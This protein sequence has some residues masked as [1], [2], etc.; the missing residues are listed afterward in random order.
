M[1]AASLNP[2]L[3]TRFAPTDWIMRLAPITYQVSTSHRRPTRKL[4]R[5]Q[6]GT[7]SNLAEQV[8][9]FKVGAAAWNATINTDST[10]PTATS[11]RTAPRLL[12]GLQQPVVADSFGAG[13]PDCP[14]HAES[15]PHVYLSQR[16]RRRAVPDRKRN[17][18]GQSAQHVDEQQ[19]SSHSLKIFTET[20]SLTHR[21]Q[22]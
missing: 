20:H 22:R 3:N 21:G 8:I 4:T 5:T 10:I 18:H 9:G 15:R 11:R 16:I 13:R 17:R 12:R 6:G 19:L 14:D 7:T 2:K 1:P